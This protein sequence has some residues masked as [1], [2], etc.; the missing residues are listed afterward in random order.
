MPPVFSFVLI[1]ANLET[2]FASKS[3][4]IGG[5]LIGF[6]SVVGAVALGYGIA[7]I[8]LFDQ[9]IDTLTPTPDLRRLVVAACDL[10]FSLVLEAGVVLT[11]VN[12]LRADTSDVSEGA[13]SR[14][15]I[16]LGASTLLVCLWV[17]ALVLTCLY[18]FVDI[19]T[20]GTAM[21]ALIGTAEL[22]SALC[23]CMYCFFAT[24]LLTLFM[25]KPA[26]SSRLSQQQQNNE[27]S[28]PL[29]YQNY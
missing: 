21:F 7:M 2:F 18:Y 10:V 26:P 3:K 4:L 25:K 20:F 14:S 6:L 1:S 16:F 28:V 27:S 24:N 23:I 22:F 29:L 15:L 12:V 11:L 13:K 19:T 17:A 8:V 9:N 5:L